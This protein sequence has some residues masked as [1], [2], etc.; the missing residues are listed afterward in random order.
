MQNLFIFDNRI[1]VVKKKKGTSVPKIAPNT[2][3]TERTKKQQ[4]KNKNRE[5]NTSMKKKKVVG[6]ESSMS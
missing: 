5:T 2:T 1:G 6:D 4:K 3:K